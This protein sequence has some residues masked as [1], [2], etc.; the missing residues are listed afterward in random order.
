MEFLHHRRIA[1]EAAE[2]EVLHISD[3][4]LDLPIE[5]RIV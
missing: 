3:Q 2:I 1:R 4:L 5:R